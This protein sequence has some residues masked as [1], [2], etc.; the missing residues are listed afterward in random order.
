M[1]TYMYAS[2]DEVGYKIITI[3]CSIILPIIIVDDIARFFNAI[4][5]SLASSASYIHQTM[6]VSIFFV[7]EM[8]ASIDANVV[9]LSGFEERIMIW[10]VFNITWKEHFWAG[11]DATA[12]WT[13]YV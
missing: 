7:D 1:V 11:P 10:I 8:W 3:V 2:Q 9:A 13:E 12:L 6:L 4:I 5:I